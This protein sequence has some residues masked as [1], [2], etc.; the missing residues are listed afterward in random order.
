MMNSSMKMSRALFTLDEMN[1]SNKAVMID[2]WNKVK[3]QMNESANENKFSPFHISFRK[4]A[5]VFN[6]KSDLPWKEAE[7][8]I[9]QFPFFLIALS[10]K[11]I[12]KEYFS[13]PVSIEEK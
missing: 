3:K 13:Q 11:K 6:K 7:Q 4:K 10:M 5:I 9:F 1:F 12:E 2:E 8:S